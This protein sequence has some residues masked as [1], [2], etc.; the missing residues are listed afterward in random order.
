MV[1]AM[2]L[3]VARALRDLE[4]LWDPPRKRASSPLPS[5]TPAVTNSTENDS[6]PGVMTRKVRVRDDS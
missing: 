2:R 3:R 1:R 6:T 5:E 4:L